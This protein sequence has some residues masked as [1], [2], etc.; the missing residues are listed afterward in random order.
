MG[1]GHLGIGPK[2]I[3]EILSHFGEKVIPVFKT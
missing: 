1:A 3:V 2:S